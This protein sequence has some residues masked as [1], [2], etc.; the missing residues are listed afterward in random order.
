MKLR[1]TLE[2][3]DLM[4]YAGELNMKSNLISHDIVKLNRRSTEAAVA[5]VKAAVSTSLSTQINVMVCIRA[6]SAFFRPS[7]NAFSSSRH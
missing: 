7:A 2:S 1:L 3:K 4:R 6:C 5:N